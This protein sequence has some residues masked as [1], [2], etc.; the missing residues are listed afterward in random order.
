M[1][2]ITCYLDFISPYAYL[3]FEQLPE[4][5]EGISHSVTYRPVLLGGLLKHHGTRGPAEVP[6]KRDWT[7]RQ[8]LWLGHAAGVPI[9]M[10]ATHPYNPLPHLRLALSTTSDGDVS[11]YVAET[12]FRDIWRGGREPLDAARLEALAMQLT[13]IRD[14]KGDAVKAQLRA[15]TDAAA[16]RGI[17]G[18]PTFE[19]DGKPFWGVDALPM[20][21][22]YLAGDAWF[23]RHWDKP[24]TIRNGLPL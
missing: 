8:V 2:H 7:Y 1:K 9:E 6:A 21:R 12:I 10:P 4:V 11:R 19:V 13:P 3:A 17:F 14:A 16:A 23:E 18:T 15:S 24:S 20:V 5:L 22:A